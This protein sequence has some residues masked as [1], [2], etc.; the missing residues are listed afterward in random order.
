MTWFDWSRKWGITLAR[1]PECRSPTHACRA[2]RRGNTVTYN[3]YYGWPDRHTWQVTIPKGDA[4][5][6][7]ESRTFTPAEEQLATRI[8]GSTERREA[9]LTAVLANK[10]G[11]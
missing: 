7:D 11:G 8:D 9:A 5:W 2:V 4:H 1:C 6:Q 10:G 3:C